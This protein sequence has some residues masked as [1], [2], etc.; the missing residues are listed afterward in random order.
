VRFYR[1][2]FRVLVAIG[3]PFGG[4]RPRAITNWVAAKAFRD[5]V[6]DDLPYTWTRD[7]R[8][9][10]FYLNPYFLL[11]RAVIAYGDYDAP[12]HRFIDRYIERGMV[13]LD[14]GANIG[15]MSVHMARRI[16]PD[17]ALFSFEPVPTVFPRLEQHIRKNGFEDRT[18]LHAV[19]LS[20]ESGQA[21]IHYGNE[22]FTNQG[23]A[24]LVSTTRGGVERT[25][26]VETARLDDFVERQGITRIDFI[27]VDI[28]GAEPLFL[29]GAQ[30][31][32]RA[33][34]PILCVEV[35]VRGLTSIP[36]YGPRDLV[37]ALEDLG[38]DLYEVAKDGDLGNPVDH[39]SIPDDY[40]AA[41][42][43][44][45]PKGKAR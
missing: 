38:Y 14:V 39:R 23:M 3:K 4:L 25:C 18:S 8:G 26:M 30:R 9:D 31:V 28:E 15:L 7:H 21:E 10:L 41:N 1:L 19:A 27:K 36:G 17:G 22:E 29:E 16:G 45:W 12:L 11:D 6:P 42:V 44:G 13:C 40:N 20:S 2:L 32:I 34:R 37:K 5:A 33:M 43:C 35:S 24:S